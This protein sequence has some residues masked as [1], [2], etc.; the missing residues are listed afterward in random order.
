MLCSPSRAKK[1]RNMARDPSMV[2]NPY[3][4]KASSSVAQATGPGPYLSPSQPEIK[5]AATHG[6]RIYYTIGGRTLDSQN[7][8]GTTAAMNAIPAA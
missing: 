2:T 3:Q 8:V 6:V 7:T 5:P 1:V 4:G